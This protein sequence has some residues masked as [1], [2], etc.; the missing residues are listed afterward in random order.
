MSHNPYTPPSAMVVDKEIDAPPPPKPKA[1]IVAQVLGVIGAA[2]LGWVIIRYAIAILEW[3]KAGFTP[4]FLFGNLGLR[5]AIF[6]ILIVMLYQLPSRSQI[7]RWAGVTVI[8]AVLTFPIYLLVTMQPENI[9][10]PAGL[11]GYILGFLLTFLPICYWLYAFAFSR[12]A[13]AY[14]G[15]SARN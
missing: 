3:R 12:K 13:R 4:T 1:V 5:V 7:G 11:A 15:S 8:L 6:A 14:F 2:A 9:D 10:T